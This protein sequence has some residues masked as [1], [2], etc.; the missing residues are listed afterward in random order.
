MSEPIITATTVI[1]G[2]AMVASGS[3]M[4]DLVIFSDGTYIYLAI[5]GAIVSMFGVMHEIF[6][7][8]SG[9]YTIG[10]IITEIIKGVLLGIAAI[11]FW[12]MAITQG[13]ISSLFHIELGQASNSLALIISFAMSWYTVPIFSWIPNYIKQRVTND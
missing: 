2:S 4:A 13:L 8:H 9:E 12:Y 3:L 6:G 7:E 10:K 1:K 5:V 11:P